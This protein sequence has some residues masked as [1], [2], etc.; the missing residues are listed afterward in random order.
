MHQYGSVSDVLRTSLY[1]Y[2]SASKLA[3][4]FRKPP[5]WGNEAGHCLG[6]AGALLLFCIVDAIGAHLCRSGLEFSV[7]GRPRRIM[8]NDFQHFFVLNSPELFGQQLSHAEIKHLYDNFRSKLVHMATPNLACPIVVNYEEPAAFPKIGGRISVNLIALH[9]RS[10]QA[11]GHFLQ[12]VDP[13]ASA[14]TSNMLLQYRA[15]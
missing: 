7:D 3:I 8:K 10:V 1:E 6:F 2:L 12:S 14:A 4:E 9:N 5:D 13:N 11:V 15:A